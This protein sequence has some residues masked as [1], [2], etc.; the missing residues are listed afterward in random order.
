[1]AQDIARSAPTEINSINGKIVQIAN[2]K[3]IQV[4][5]N[6][7]LLLLVKSQIAAGASGDIGKWRS[8]TIHLPIE[9]R[10]Q[11]EYLSHFGGPS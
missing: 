6:Q 2:I 4:P 9:L 8:E 7:A 3:N 5:V 11:F 1:M 10:N